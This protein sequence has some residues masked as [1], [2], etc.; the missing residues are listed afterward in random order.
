MMIQRPINLNFNEPS[1]GWG[2]GG[3]LDPQWGPGS[4]P[5]WGSSEGQGPFLSD[6]D[7]KVSISLYLSS[8]ATY[9]HI[10][11]GQFLRWGGGAG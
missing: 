6:N 2:S 4:Q 10:F 7:F 3:C 5:W 11:K 1:M 9:L 8:P